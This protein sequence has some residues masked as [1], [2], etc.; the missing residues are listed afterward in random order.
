MNVE[1]IKQTIYDTITNYVE[2]NEEDLLQLHDEPEYLWALEQ[3]Q[4]R[5][6]L[7]RSW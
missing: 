6:N 5:T 7:V 4:K 2:L 1:Q 3:E